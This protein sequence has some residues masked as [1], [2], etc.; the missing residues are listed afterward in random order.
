M[1][2]DFFYTAVQGIA[3]RIQ[4]FGA[5]VLSL[6]DAVQ[7]IGGESLLV[8]QVVFC[9]A[10]AEHGFVKGFVANHCQSPLI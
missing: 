8:D 1:A 10:F 2:N 3:Q 4:C 6:L 9:D 5:D 7:R